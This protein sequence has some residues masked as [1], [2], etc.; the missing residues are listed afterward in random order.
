MQAN[1]YK[2][3][4]GMGN[5]N[6]TTVINPIACKYVE[7]GRLIQS[8]NLCKSCK[9]NADLKIKVAGADTQ[10]LKLSEENEWL[11]CNMINMKENDV[12]L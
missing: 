12:R 10:L 7:C 5:G 1:A 9:E 2:N 8:G 6:G 11:K 4:K 3:A